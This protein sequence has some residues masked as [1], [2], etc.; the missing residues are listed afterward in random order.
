MKINNLILKSVSA[1]TRII[2]TLKIQD[3]QNYFVNNFLIKNF[4]QVTTHYICYA[5]QI[6][7]KKLFNC[8]NAIV[9]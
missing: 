9:A 6:F 3:D 4:E 2:L 5:L 7:L 8:C 1:F